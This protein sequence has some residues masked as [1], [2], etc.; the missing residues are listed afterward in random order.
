MR[1]FFALLLICTASLSALEIPVDAQLICLSL[2]RD[3]EVWLKTHPSL[4]V[5]CRFVSHDPLKGR[6][7]IFDF[8]CPAEDFESELP[9]FLESCD[10]EIES[11]GGYPIGLVAVGPVNPEV[12]HNFLIDWYGQK[13]TQEQSFYEAIQL[14]PGNQREEADLCLSYP[15]EMSAI[16]TDVDVKKLWIF[17]LIQSMA[18]GR[19]KQATT[20]CGGKWQAPSDVR[21]L[22]P[23]V[24]TV[25]RGVIH[26]MAS[27][28]LLIHFLQ[29]IQILKEQG[30]TESEFV[31][32]KSRLQRHLKRFYDP[33]PDQQVQ[34]D[35][36]A[37]YLAAQLPCPAYET[38]MA[39]SL[40]MVSEITMADIAEML[41][42]SLLDETRC[43][44]LS[45]PEGASSSREEIQ[46]TLNTYPSN[47]LVFDYEEAQKVV[48]VEGQDPFSQLPITEVEQSMIRS[49][50]HTVAKTHVLKLPFIR[51]DLEEKRRQLL[52]I[53]PLCSLATFVTDQYTKQ[54]LAEILDSRL[55]GGHF[56]SDFCGRMK[57]EAEKNNLSI[58]IP[59]FCKAVRANPDQVRFY[60][61]N[62]DYVKLIHY[63]IK[64]NNN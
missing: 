58:Y 47:S 44:A 5:A 38:F 35:Y 52:H 43:V 62:K 23:S 9:C 63:L 3:M 31:N 40:Q 49:I 29:A 18:E 48:L 4:S 64:L 39:T 25:G 12:L 37:S 20:E 16:Q 34:V 32:Y 11:K 53:H 27:S 26:H 41:K 10:D 51:S 60:I 6:P 13:E 14:F 28:Q 33:F 61:N 46:Q 2:P 15:A 30:F 17:F 57:K 36:Y 55:K 54:C 19:L 7:E 45:L 8:D 59:G 21:Y 22:L 50:L 1:R 24:A 42:T 56:A